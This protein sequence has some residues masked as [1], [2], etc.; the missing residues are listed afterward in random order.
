[1]KEIGKD[2]DAIASRLDLGSSPR[3]ILELLEEII[4]RDEPLPPSPKS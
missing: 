2:V 1:M 4:R 3:G